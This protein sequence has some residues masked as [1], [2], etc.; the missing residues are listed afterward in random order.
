MSG[1]DELTREE[2]IERI[3]ARHKEIEVLKCEVDMLRSILTGGGSGSSAAPFVKPNRQQRREEERK[4]RKKR[5][6]S[7]ARKRDIPT[8]TVEHAVDRCP[9]CSGKL[10]GGWV[11]SSRQIIEIPDTPA[12]LNI[13]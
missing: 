8:E 6:Q 12:L 4:A 9:E 5:T 13:K 7:F 3:K 1:L 11:H 10:S 2:L